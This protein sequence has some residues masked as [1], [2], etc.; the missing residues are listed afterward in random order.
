MERRSAGSSR[1]AE[2]WGGAR[3][4]D[5]GARTEELEVVIQEQGILIKE[6]GTLIQVIG[7]LIYDLRGRSNK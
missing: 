2:I 7:V 1:A 4:W 5:Q 3:G 6:Q